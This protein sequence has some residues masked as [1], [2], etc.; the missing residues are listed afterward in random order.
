M[1]VYSIDRQTINARA[2]NL[3]QQVDSAFLRIQ[4][5]KTFLDTIPDATLI[6]A[7][8]YAQ[9]DIDLLRSSLTDM[10]QLRTIYQGAAALASAKDFRAFTKQI[11]PFGSL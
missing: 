1:A 7:Y 9:G 6:S 11:Y 4:Q 5:F 3:I 8:G 10:E 2:G